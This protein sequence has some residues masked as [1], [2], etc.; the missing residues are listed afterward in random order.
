MPIPEQADSQTEIQRQTGFYPPV[1]LYVRFV[2]LVAVVVIAL[3]A[4]LLKGLDST[5]AIGPREQE[6]RKRVS[7]A[8]EAADVAE[9]QN[10]LQITG[11]RSDCL[12]ELTSLSDHNLNSRLNPVRCDA[13]A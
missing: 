4:V 13:F 12:I 6:I 8:I 2:N 11:V 7:R 3:R 10:A 1:V 5:V 9:C